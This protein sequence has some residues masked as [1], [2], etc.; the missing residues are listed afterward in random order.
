MILRLQHRPEDKRQKGN[1]ADREERSAEYRVGRPRPSPP[2]KMESPWARAA[3]ELQGLTGAEGNWLSRLNE[4]QARPSASK[5]CSPSLKRSS[6]QA[7][8]S[9]YASAPSLKLLSMTMD[10]LLSSDSPIIGTGE[11]RVKGA[12]PWSAG[13][14]PEVRKLQVGRRC[15]TKRKDR[16]RSSAGRLRG[17]GVAGI[18]GAGWKRRER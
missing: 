11:T 14:C 6:Q 3:R 9:A 5:P 12:A 4:N 8:E 7:P 17:P 18:V 10:H 2:G 16:A 1:R 15:L 13:G